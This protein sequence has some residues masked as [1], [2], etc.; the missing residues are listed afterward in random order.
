MRCQKITMATEGRSAVP[1]QVATHPHLLSPL[2]ALFGGTPSRLASPI[3][4]SATLPS[5]TFILSSQASASR[6]FH[7]IPR[8]RPLAPAREWAASMPP[9]RQ[10]PGGPPGTPPATSP[11]THT[12]SG[13]YHRPS[14]SILWIYHSSPHALF[15]SRCSLRRNLFLF[16][17]V[18]MSMSLR[19]S[20]IMQYV[21]RISVLPCPRIR[22]VEL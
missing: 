18:V 14:E 19:R 9:R 22:C 8:P 5:I 21:M 11:P 15:S 10:S 7:Q 3:Y 6:S 13:T 1:W 17:L 12:P 4:S 16:F 20:Y 2:A